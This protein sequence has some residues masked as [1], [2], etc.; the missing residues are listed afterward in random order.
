MNVRWDGIGDG[1]RNMSLDS[2][3]LADA[4]RGIPGCRVYTWDTPW[5]TLGRFQKPETALV[6][7]Y[8]LFTIRPTGGRAV[9]HGHDMT[10]GFA[11]PNPTDSRSI[12][13]I[14][15]LLV[16]PLVSALN[17]C[18]LE[19][20]IAED[21]HYANVG[22][23][24]ADCFAFSSPND[25]VNPHTGKKVCGCALRVTEHGALLQASIPYKD[26]LIDPSL[27]VKGGVVMPNEP[28]DAA[29]L[30]DAMKEVLN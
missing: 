15:R 2:E 27:A 13:P 4:E 16:G 1:P 17:L 26:P 23:L 6:D 20:V 5:I 19:C 29:R 11:L 10:V 22:K 7:G 24:S 14:Y 9:M 28:W 12:K 8:E 3:L 21:S 18:G 25:V 30:F